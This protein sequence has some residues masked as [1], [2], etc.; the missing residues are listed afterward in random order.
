MEHKIRERWEELCE[1]ALVEHDPKK[2]L[3]IIEELNQVLEERHKQLT[4]LE[5]NSDSKQPAR[6][7]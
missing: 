4:A 2:F 7:A 3:A 5:K 1:R 6:S